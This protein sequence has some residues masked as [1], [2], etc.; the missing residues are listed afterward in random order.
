MNCVMVILNYNSSR[1][2]SKNLQKHVRYLTIIRSLLIIKVLYDFIIYLTENLS[3]DIDR[4][5]QFIIKDLEQEIMLGKN[6]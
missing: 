5:N 2:A 1:R 6:M 3:S 4:V